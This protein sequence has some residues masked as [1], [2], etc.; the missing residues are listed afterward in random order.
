MLFALSNKYIKVWDWFFHSRSSIDRLH[1][2]EPIVAEKLA[3]RPSWVDVETRRRPSDSAP[4][5]TG[6]END[7]FPFVV[8]SFTYLPGFERFMKPKT[9]AEIVSIAETLGGPIIYLNSDR[10]LSHALAVLPGLD[11]VIHIPLLN[12][13]YAQLLQLSTE[14]IQSPK[15]FLREDTSVERKGHTVRPRPIN[16]QPPKRHL[17]AILLLEQLWSAVV[18]PVLDGLGIQVCLQ[19]HLIP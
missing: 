5:R 3:Q 13:D 19:H 11:D 7:E 10:F 16:S 12:L 6:D 1:D 18:K 17:R 14:F 9:P 15:G 8:Q 2:S 4:K